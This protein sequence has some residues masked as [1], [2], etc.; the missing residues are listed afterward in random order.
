MSRRLTHGEMISQAGFLPGEV[1]ASRNLRAAVCNGTASAED[2]LAYGPFAAKWDKFSELI[3]ERDRLDQIERLAP[4]PARYDA[5][6]GGGLGSALADLRAGQAGRRL[7][8]HRV[9]MIPVDVGG[10][11][12]QDMPEAQPLPMYRGSSSSTGHERIAAA[13]AGKKR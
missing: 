9:K 3:G 2:Q 8:V 4:D 7:T 11:A 1:E 12:L 6:Q 13:F 10:G 5:D